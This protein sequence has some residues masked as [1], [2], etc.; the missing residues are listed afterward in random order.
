MKSTLEI[1]REIREAA[2]RAPAEPGKRQPI[3]DLFRTMDAAGE[4]AFLDAVKEPNRKVNHGSIREQIR[5][6]T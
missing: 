2:K 1:I 3:H 4:L 6:R 5:R